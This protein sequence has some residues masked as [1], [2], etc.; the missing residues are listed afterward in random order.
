MKRFYIIDGLRSVLALCVTIGHAGVFPLF[1]PVGQQDA[2]LNFL[3][4]GLR[5]VVFG[6]PA[7][8]AFFVISGFCIHY[9]F[10]E[11]KS[12]CPILQFYARRYIRILIPVI[13]TVATFKI[14]FPDRIIIGRD[15]I[16]W[17]STLWSVLC[18]EIYYAMYP[19]LNRL[20]PRFGWPNILKVA[21][22]MAI[23]VS[24]YFFLGQDWQDLGIIATALTLFPVWLMG[25]YLAETVSSLS[26][27]YTVREIWVWRFAAWGI[28]WLASILHFHL[29]IYQTQTGLWVGVIYYFWIR[30]EIGYFGTRKPWN[31]LIWSGQ[32]SYSLYLI[33]P[34]IIS[35]CVSHH[36]WAFESRLDWVLTMVFILSASY[37]FYLAIERPSHTVARTV[38]LLAP[39]QVERYAAEVRAQ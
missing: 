7:V 30:A 6:P 31:W 39:D 2:V 4:R 33:H 21:F 19:L 10:V 1:G 9:P 38:P 35:L 32:W 36:I 25:C 17:H 34:I 28:M 14:V 12:K 26:K 37:A 18:E 23:P 22:G 13:C 24:W 27:R 15:S 16:L 29:G 5:S 20:G 8:M 3:A 11:S